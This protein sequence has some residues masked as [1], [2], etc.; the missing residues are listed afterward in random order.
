MNVRK[1]RF[2]LLTLVVAA[3]LVAGLLILNPSGG[4]ESPSSIS[5]PIMFDKMK[6]YC[7]G[8]YLV[9]VPLE[10]EM[11]EQRNSYV[12]GTINVGFGVPEYRDLLK[13]TLEKRK[14]EQGKR[15]FKFVRTE[16]PEEGDRQD[17]Q[18]I[19]SMADLYGR[20][21]YG[22]D[23]F[24]LNPKDKPGGGYFFYLLEQSYNEKKIEGIV[25]DFHNILNN[26]RYRH[27]SEIPTEPGFCF[28]DG[29]VANDGKE[30][31]WEEAVI[32]FRLKNNPDVIFKIRSDVPFKTFPSVL[33]RMKS[34]N[35]FARFPG[36]IKTLLSGKRQINGMPGEEL[37]ASFPAEDKTGPVH[38]ITWETLGELRNPLKPNIQLEIES[39]YDASGMGG[40]TASS[41]DTKQMLQ[42]Y[43]AIVT[44]IRFRPVTEAPAQSTP[45]AD[46]K[47]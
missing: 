44:T 33:E 36:R 45:A 37:A 35:I 17:R 25:L 19:V 14:N 30:P 15:S 4:V 41:L 32:R 1:H 2:F 29:F 23:A 46:V 3:L 5:E 6:T 10:A 26:V 21:S 47:P 24:T 31:Q 34:S 11:L 13:K 18:I 12:F 7:F 16:Y 39:G 38:D 43:E 9:D 28:R 42:L 8:R 20:N 27:E 22:V 40:A